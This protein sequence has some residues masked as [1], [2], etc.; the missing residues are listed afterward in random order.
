MQN[1]ANF[2]VVVKLLSIADDDGIGIAQSEKQ[3]RNAARGRRD[4]MHQPF[5]LRLA[6]LVNPIVRPTASVPSIFDNLPCWDYRG[7]VMS[8]RGSSAFLF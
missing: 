1:A 8:P 4:A 7:S 2:F 3:Q 6:H 5:L